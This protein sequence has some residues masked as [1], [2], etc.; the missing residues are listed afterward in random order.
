M[1]GAAAAI[2][3]IRRCHN[4]LGNG[5][6]LPCNQRRI[7]Y[8]RDSQCGIESLGHDVDGRCSW[9]LDLKDRGIRVNTIRPGATQ[10]P[11]L[12]DLAGP[13]ATQ[14]QGLLDYLASR[15]PMRRLG[16]PEEIAGAAHFLASDDT[17]FV[18]GAELFVD[19]GQA[20]I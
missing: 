1:D 15:I 4:D 7:R 17:S 10:T 8:S 18:N 9:I 3:V 20:Q 5:T 6:Q 11:G 19:G 12:V 14:Q 13:D 2:Q 16:E